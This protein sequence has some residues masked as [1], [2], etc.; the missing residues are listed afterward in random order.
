MTR[1]GPTLQAQRVN[2]LSPEAAQSLARLGIAT[3]SVVA[4]EAANRRADPEA[5]KQIR[6]RLHLRSA[7]VIDAANG[8]VC[9]A[10]IWDRSDGGRRLV[11]ANN[12]GLPPRFGFYEDEDGAIF[13]ATLAWRRG[14]VVGARIQRPGPPSPMKPTQKTALSGRYYALRD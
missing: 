12:V 2:G 13:T 7:K 4:G 8:F 1:S 10:M 11:L 6:Q 5:R 14:P 3:Y 9:D